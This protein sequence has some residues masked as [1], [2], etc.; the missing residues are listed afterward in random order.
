MKKRDL[1]DEFIDELGNRIPKRADLI[2]R[3]SDILRLEKE[4]IYRRMAGKVNFSIREMGIL[5]KELHISLDSLLY[6]EE[7]TQ[8]FPFILGIPLKF[9][10][11]NALCD[12]VDL[13]LKRIGNISRAGPC[14]TGKVYHT[15]PLELFIHFPLIMKFMFF[16]WG[17]YFV[18]SEEFNNFSRWELPDRLST[19][20]E[21]YHDIN[22][23][24]KAFYIWD[25]SL[26]WALSKEIDN[27]YRMHI[28]TPQEK[29][30][31]KNDLKSLLLKLEKTLNGTFIPNI[32]LGPQ[33]AFYVSSIPMGFTSCYYQSE[34]QRLATLQT[35]FSF[36]LLENS[37]EN[38]DKVKE[39]I[40][41]FR[42]IS[43]LLSESGRIE[44]RLFFEAQ[45][46][47]IDNI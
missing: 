28:I 45:Y 44:R 14:E 12:M 1:H 42:N 19:I 38:L 32:P 10:S 47:I 20:T 36:S 17:N 21:K 34:T 5:A 37:K 40:K 35:N 39:W 41:S 33:I 13:N 23:F 26:I 3:A 30:E 25:N 18:N 43:T 6:R 9:H 24:Q 11:I 31:I 7:D 22:N 29:E 46:K 15:L 4:S 27:F 2:S 8:W 16:K